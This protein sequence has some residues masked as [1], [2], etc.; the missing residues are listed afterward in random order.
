VRAWPTRGLWRHGDF[1]RLW[2][3]QTISQF[4]SQISLVAIPLVAILT[5]EAS[6]FEVAALS[7]VEMLPFL[8]IALPAGVWVDRLPRKPILVLGDLG[9]ALALSTIPLAYA[10][11]ALTIGHL[12]VVGFVVGIC[13]VFFDVAY[14][15]YLPSL[16]AREQLV[17]GNSKLEISR[18]GAQLA[19]PGVGGLLVSAIG[20][21]YAV[22]VDAVSFAWSGGIVARI[23]QAE[24]FEPAVEERN[25]RR[26]LVE[27]LRYLLGDARWRALSL[28]IATVNFFSSVAFSIF[29]VYAV[30]VLDWSPALI[31][32]V[33][34][35]GNVG[36]LIGAALASR[37]SA[38]LGIGR[39]LVFGGVLSGGAFLLIPLA[40]ADEAVPIVLTA[41]TLISFG[42]VLFNVTG[43]SLFQALTPQRILGRMNASRRW[44]VWGT[45]PLGNLA[46]GVL[47]STIGL[48]PT[49][50]VGAVGASL[51]CAFLLARP[52]RT[53]RRLP[54]PEE[55]TL[56]EELVELPLETQSAET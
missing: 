35:L 36:W 6:P 38:R 46:G 39:T 23:R 55:P 44:L 43:L 20:A 22:L 16:V 48:R 27:G 13:T 50:T 41:M 32:V 21:P 42:V 37:V 11:D 56:L 2:G 17:E 49:I 3:A 10:F 53:I 52:V 31:G 14:Q 12:Y 9:R 4:G 28:Y 51:C 30:R 1:L 40:P 47:A 7:A 5:L 19:G 18:S 45:I 24:Q 34:A 29:L 54:E 8:L 26:E 15:S 25:M 33:F